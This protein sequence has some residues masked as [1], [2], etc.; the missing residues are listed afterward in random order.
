MRIKYIIVL[1]LIGS[2]FSTAFSQNSSGHSN[3]A[4][5]EKVYLQLDNEV[6]TT[7]NTVWFKAIVVNA[8]ALSTELSSGVLYVDLIRFDQ[9]L[10]ESKL[11]KLTD[12]VG[13]GHF[14]LDRSYED[15]S[16]QIRAYTEWNRNFG[17]DFVFEKTIQIFSQQNTVSSKI[18]PI[19][20]TKLMGSKNYDFIDLQF[21][22]EGGK[23]IDNIQSKVGFKA[24]DING[25]GV[26]VEGEI[27]DSDK[28]SVA[29]FSSNTLGM[30][31][32]VMEK[33]DFDKS[34]SAKV[35]QISTMIANQLF[36]LPEISKLGH[37]LRVIERNNN[38][39][40]GVNS[41]LDETA[42]LTL[43]ASLRGLNYFDAS[44]KLIVN[45]YIQTIPKADFPEGVISF[46]LYNANDKPVAERLYFNDNKQL[47]LQ[48]S[49]DL[50][51]K[52]P[53][54]RDYV[55]LMLEA[56]HP[57]DSI[58]NMSASVLVL[59]KTRLTDTNDKRQ[60]I[61]S[62]LLLNSDLRGEIESATSYFKENSDLSI[63]DLMLTQGWRNY[64]YD[65]NPNTKFK[66]LKENQIALKGVVNVDKTKI[67]EDSIDFLIMS[68]GDDTMKFTTTIDTPGS[69]LLPI[70]DLYGDSKYVII[71]P[72]GIKAKHKKHVDIALTKNT[73]LPIAFN[74][75]N[76][77]SLMDTKIN[78]IVAQNQKYRQIE[79]NYF[80]DIEGINVLDEVIL[81]NY[82]MTPKRKEMFNRYGEPDLVISGKEIKEKSKNENSNLYYVLFAF[83][84]KI[85]VKRGDDGRLMVG[86]TNGGKYHQNFV[87]IDGVP[88]RELDYFLLEDIAVKEVTSVEV[89]DDPRRL[90]ELHLDVK[91][92]FPRSSTPMFGSI[93]SIYTRSG[94]GL[95]G[96]LDFSKNKETFEIQ[97]FSPTK[98]FYTPKYDSKDTFYIK[99]PDYRSAIYWKPDL[100][101]DNEGNA[102]LGYYHSD[103][104]GNFVMIIEAISKDG[105]IG[106]YELDYSVSESENN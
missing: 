61:L 71:E 3:T 99:K 60:N 95:F 77:V 6:Y 86:T 91:G 102:E 4:L 5:A 11:I 56:K 22:P 24:I 93:I 41:N 35:T 106:Y 28:N 87:V 98:D 96:A 81:N 65:F 103:N 10:I 21:F 64:K 83:K 85:T 2:F 17:N 73:K 82:K 55:K 97:A 105:K 49:A 76:D 36:D 18:E 78:N 23:L 31:H 67:E 33:P 50:N 20:N 38:L 25:K 44:F 59:D 89:I 84:D 40:I 68:F 100:K 39:V 52:T 58:N 43:K 104:E 13:S 74:P 80:K 47:R 27:L 53:N 48:L 70:D 15:G 66:H 51:N 90:R 62:Y 54:K 12:G 19:H 16:Y 8:A 34:Y 1:L 72:F 7:N 63:D 75:E 9:E 26:Y 45:Q 57:L 32:F 30:G 46:T 42:R 69:F 94:K 88:V 14:D 29:S 101:F 92:F 79:S 37:T